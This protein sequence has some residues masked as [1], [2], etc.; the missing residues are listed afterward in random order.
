MELEELVVP[1]TAGQWTVMF[2]DWVMSVADLL[3]DGVEAMN[4][5]WC[6]IDDAF[7]AIGL[8][9]W[10]GSFDLV[11]VTGFPSLFIVASVQVLNGITEFIVGWSLSQ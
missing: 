9:Q 1:K 5:V 11:S 4:F 7:G 10:V 3:D 8:N 2:D 6:V